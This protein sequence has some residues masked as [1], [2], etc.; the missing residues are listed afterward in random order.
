MNKN[1]WLLASA[2][3]LFLTNNVVFIAINGLVGLQLAPFGWMATL[4]VMGY[5]VGGA[6]S[7]PLVAQSQARWGR[8]V[9]FQI[10]LA[11]AVVSL[12]MFLAFRYA[13]RLLRALGDAGTAV[14]RITASDGKSHYAA[15]QALEAALRATAGIGEVH[16]DAERFI[17]QLDVRVDQVKAQAAG[18]SSSDI[19]R[20][21]DQVLSGATISHFREGDTVLPIVLRGDAAWRTRI[22]QLPALPIQKADGSG[23]VPLGQV[24][25]VQLTPQPSVIQRYN[26]ERAITVTAKHPNMTAQGVADS[27]QSTLQQ[28]QDPGNA[29]GSVRVALGGEIEESAS[30][31]GAIAQLLPVCVVAMFILFVWQFESVRKSLIVLAS[32]PFVS[33]GAA[34]ALIATGTTLTFVGTLGLLALAG[35]IVNNAV[36][37]LDAIEEARRS[38][39]PAA[40]AI[41]DAASKRLRP[42][43]MTKMV[44]I[45]GLV[46]LWLFGGA[47]WTSLAVVMMGGLALGTLI[48]LGLIPALY[49]AA[50]RVQIN[51]L[52]VGIRAG[53]QDPNLGRN[54]RLPL[55]IRAAAWATIN[56][57]VLWRKVCRTMLKDRR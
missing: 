17:Q 18:V 8:K 53:L 16:N 55:S 7:T 33:I 26:Q 31:N 44:C 27:V 23:S 38:G 25:T 42:I 40:E 3:G 43:V 5:V 20:S 48:T 12:L 46:P 14:F 28:L 47:V 51:E 24:A 45:L 19:A 30:A 13:P 56:C 2:Q 29:S 4:P 36:L 50:Y 49:A 52:G 41:E 10:G 37:L 39:M 21:L 11:V 9:S 57:P 22:E 6:L 1:L 35:I 32:I 54:P 15:A 34:L